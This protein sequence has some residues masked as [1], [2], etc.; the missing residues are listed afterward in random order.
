MKPSTSPRRLVQIALAAA[1]LI[2]PAEPWS[3]P[4]DTAF[5]EAARQFQKA[6]WS[7]A[8]GRFILLANGGDRDAARIALFMHRYG[9]QLYG[10]YWDA[11]AEDVEL[12]TQLA[13]QGRGRAPPE[14]RPP[15]YRPRK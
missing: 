12:W 2:L 15:E 8:Y 14:Y 5:E 7:D 13:S 3:A 1:F 9:P 11:S 10:S 4:R 6:R